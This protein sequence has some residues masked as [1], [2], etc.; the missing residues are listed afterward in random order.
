MVLI[1]TWQHNYVIATWQVRVV[2]TGCSPN[3]EHNIDISEF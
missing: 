3:Q 1:S 2:I